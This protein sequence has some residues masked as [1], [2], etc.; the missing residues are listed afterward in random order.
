MGKPDDESSD[1]RQTVLKL[2]SKPC[3]QLENS[4]SLQ[5]LEPN[6]KKPIGCDNCIKGL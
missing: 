2:D 3:S 4:Q 1:I 6:P 5:T